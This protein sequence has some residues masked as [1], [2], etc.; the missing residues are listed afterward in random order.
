MRKRKY[1]RILAST[2]D[3]NKNDMRLH[4][5]QEMNEN[6][7]LKN[8]LLKIDKKTPCLKFNSNKTKIVPT[9]HNM[10][11]TS[12]VLMNCERIDLEIIAKAMPNSSYDR[13]RFAAITIRL[14]NPR[15]TAL[16][17]SSGKL[18][19]TG[20]L[21]TQMAICANRCIVFRMKQIFS[22]MSVRYH[23]FRIQNIVCNISMDNV[24]SIDIQK[25]YEDHGTICT[26]QASIF[27]GMIWRPLDSPIVLLVFKSSRI[28]VTGGKHY[29]D[30][31]I[32]FQN[33]LEIIKPY[34][35]YE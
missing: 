18:V 26:Y 27:P 35:I 22:N 12:H 23:A 28:V 5:Y 29:Q 21:S 6:E 10:V 19:V 2:L 3:F 8:L 13:K 1:K 32:G 14:D 34:C 30:I 9:T 11:C 4:K 7:C 31:V 24:K 17:F 15:A 33:I 16:L 20:A 25:F